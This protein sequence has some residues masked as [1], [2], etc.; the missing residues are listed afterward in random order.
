MITIEDKFR[1]IGAHA[2]EVDRLTKERTD[3]LAMSKI[4][5]HIRIISS[6]I[7]DNISTFYYHLKHNRDLYVKETDEWYQRTCKESGAVYISP[8]KKEET[9]ES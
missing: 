5:R 8:F 3:T 2:R 1:F 4:D 6:L 7:N 9:A